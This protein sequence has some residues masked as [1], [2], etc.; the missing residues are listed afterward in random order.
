M[1][2]NISTP[3]TTNEGFVVENAFGRVAVLNNVQGTQLEYST[4][5]YVSE[6]AFEAGS[7]PFYP[8]ALT[9]GGASPYDYSTATANILD[10]AHDELIALL[11]AQGVVA[12]KSL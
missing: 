4:N 6:A 8:G 5:F 1:S 3:L 11:A 10:I 2:L 9:L 12:T 7:V